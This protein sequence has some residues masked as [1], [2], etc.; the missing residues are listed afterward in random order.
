MTAGLTTHNLQAIVEFP[1]RQPN[2]PQKLAVGAALSLAAMVVPIVP[3]LFVIGYQKAVARRAIHTGELVLPEW[4][5]WSGYLLDGLKVFGALM[6]LSLPAILA[7]TLGF[8]GMMVAG[9]GAAITE[10]ASTAEQ[11]LWAGPLLLGSLAGIALFGLGIALIFVLGVFT[12]VAIAHLIATDDFAAAFRVREWWPI[13][14]ANLGGFLLAHLLVMGAGFVFSLVSQILQLTLVL[15]CLL[16]VVFGA[17]I[18]YGGTLSSSLF[19]LAYREGKAKLASQGG[20][21]APA[22]PAT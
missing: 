13:L 22:L 21:P 19:A 5:D 3:G 11:A 18:M 4:D 7:F 12:P 6:I 2:G 16:P 15:C 14:R 17:Y 8:G 1:F 20:A 10:D 9:M